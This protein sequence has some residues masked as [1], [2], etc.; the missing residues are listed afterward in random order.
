[1][2]MSKRET[3]ARFSLIISK[4]RRKP[5]TFAEISNTLARE[6]EI[7]GYDF[8]ISIRTFQR[9]LEEIRSL[10]DID[11]QYDFS[12]KVYKIESDDQSEVNKRIWEAFDTFHALNLTNQ[13]SDCIDFEKRRSGGTENLY[14]L[15]HAVK[16]HVQIKFTYRKYWED[17]LTHRRAEP[18]ALKEFRNRWY[19]LVND[20]KDNSIKTF[21]LDRLSDLE[22]TNT[23]FQL[24]ADFNVNEYFKYCFGIVRPN[25]AKPQEVILSFLPVQGK[26]VKS[27]P[28][29]E[30]QQ[31]L[32]D[33]EQELRVKL[34]VFITYDFMMEL[35]SYGEKV[36]VLTPANLVAD[37][38]E[39][40]QNALKRY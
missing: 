24:P 5:A 13:L 21:A 17:E 30:S 29:H 7:Q 19:L 40:Y 8:N 26:Y 35:L 15:L 34:T 37:M 16:T 10:Y 22:I 18:Y 14:G 25:E 1:M 2:I 4:L 12:K 32:I 23:H 3:L 36:K 20:L 33:N 31:I 6:S 11:I 28:L 9:D 38:K 39:T 27:L